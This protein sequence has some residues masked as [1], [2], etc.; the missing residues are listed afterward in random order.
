MLLPLLLAL[1]CGPQS[2]MTTDEPAST[3]EPASGTTTTTS[4]TGPT[5]TAPTPTTGTTTP[6]TAT[7][8]DD[9]GSTSEGA[10]FIIPPEPC[11][12]VSGGELDLRCSQLPCSLWQQNC[13]RGEKCVPF[14]ADGDP[15]VD[16]SRCVPI[17]PDPGQPGEPCTV[18]GNSATGIDSCDLGAVCWDV[19]ADTLSG[20]CVAL[21]EG[22]AD[23]PICDDPA[24]ACA[25]GGDGV[26]N[27]CLPACDPLAPDCAADELCAALGSEFT[28]LP[29]ASGDEGQVFDP[30]EFVNACEPGL[31]CAATAAAFECDPNAAGCCLPYCD[32]DLPP[33]CPGAM[34]QC[35]PWYPP[36]EAPPGHEDLGVCAVPQ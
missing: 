5:T 15:V 1:A 31:A 29:D 23:E 33:N 9:A 35:L 12:L 16:S 28:C 36:G 17:L 4:T 32:L 18:E 14:S 19:D 26:L 30:C 20:T 3:G 24:T 13:P 25:G 21:C 10:T 27:I 11:P 6:P 8:E 2:P 22:S 7:S 34:Q